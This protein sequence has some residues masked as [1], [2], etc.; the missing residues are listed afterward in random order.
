MEIDH[1][2]PT[3][4][5]RQLI[6]PNGKLNESKKMRTYLA[7]PMRGLKLFNFP[8]FD[9]AAADL[10]SQG[11]E[12]ISPADLDRQSGFDPVSLPEDWDWR[13]LPE[14]FS[15]DAAMK[16]DL[17]ALGQVDA[18]HMLPGWQQSKGATAERAVAIWRGLAVFEYQPVNRQVVGLFGFYGSGKDEAAKPL[19]A[20]GWQRVSFAEPLR[21][22]ALS[23]DPVVRVS[24]APFSLSAVVNDYG[25]T[26]AKR[27]PD[28]R[29]F[30]QR[31]GTEGVRNVI[32]ANTWVELAERSMGT[33]SVVFTDVRF[34]NE[35]DLIRKHGGKLVRI[36]RPG[37]K[38]A[39]EHASEVYPFEPDE[40]IIND[41]TIEELHARMKRAVGMDCRDWDRMIAADASLILPRADEAGSR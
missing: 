18:I 2:P 24:D 10:R 5:L 31:L 17:E 11:V 27:F 38:P 4:L 37:C 19:I 16:R 3:F 9:A 29:R 15:L 12:V 7:G 21:Q 8:A 32:G 1:P 25:W 23:I 6:F 36:V 41:G 39:T 34:P 30:L 33:Q 26:E 20:S 40:T 35:V 14:H 28:V 13:T 22:M